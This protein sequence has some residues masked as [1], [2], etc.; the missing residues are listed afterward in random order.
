[1]TAKEILNVQDYNP[2]KLYECNEV[3]PIPIK[4]RWSS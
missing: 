1:L 4:A 2:M 3:H